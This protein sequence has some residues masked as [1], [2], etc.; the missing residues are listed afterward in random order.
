MKDVFVKEL[1]AIVR[2]MILD[3]SLKYPELSFEDIT[4]MAYGKKDCIGSDE[5]AGKFL[6]IG[7]K[8]YSPLKKEF[9][10]R[11]I[12]NKEQFPVEAVKSIILHMPYTD[13]LGTP[14]WKSIAKYV[15]DRDGNRCVKCGTDRRLH[16]HH[17]NYQNHGDELHHL[18]DLICVC[19]KCHK[20]IHGNRT[21]KD[22][23][24]D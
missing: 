12:E 18:D 9:I 17:L 19:R 2:L 10:Y 6:T 23:S 8:V 4:T 16:V 11:F 1:Q 24:K 7:E 22:T 13:F 14:Y 20:E 21:H 3:I 15:K 5:F